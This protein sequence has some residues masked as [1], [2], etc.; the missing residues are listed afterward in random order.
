MER[1]PRPALALLTPFR[2]VVLILLPESPGI[3]IIALKCLPTLHLFF[4]AGWVEPNTPVKAYLGER[5]RMTDDV[6]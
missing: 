5:K 1:Q 2:K 3:S 4:L 6:G